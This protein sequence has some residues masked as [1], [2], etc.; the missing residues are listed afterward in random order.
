MAQAAVKSAKFS[1]LV[2]GKLGMS[3]R[4]CRAELA[5]KLTN[6]LILAAVNCEFRAAT[7]APSLECNSLNTLSLLPAKPALLRRLVV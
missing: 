3:T 5:V 7:A 2:G 1:A 4:H 6:S